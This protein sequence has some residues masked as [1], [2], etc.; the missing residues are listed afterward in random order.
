MKG[1][2]GAEKFTFRTN[3]DAEEYL[4]AVLALS[5]VPVPDTAV[6]VRNIPQDD[7]L[8]LEVLPT[9]LSSLQGWAGGTDPS[10]GQKIMVFGI[11]IHDLILN[12]P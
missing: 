9:T 4:E 5:S 2:S 3:E 11:N 6:D 12:S 7:E 8:P 10:I 1:I